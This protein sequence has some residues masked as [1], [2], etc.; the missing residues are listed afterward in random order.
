MLLVLLSLLSITMMSDVSTS[1]AA[2]AGAAAAAERVRRP[3]RSADAE[4]PPPELSAKRHPSQAWRTFG[5][6]EAPAGGKNSSRKKQKRG[7]FDAA[8]R[9]AAEQLRDK[10]VDDFLHQPVRQR[11]ERQAGSISS[12]QEQAETASRPTRS[13]APQPGELKPSNISGGS[14]P[15][16]C[17]AEYPVSPRVVAPRLNAMCI[18]VEPEALRKRE[19]Q[20]WPFAEVS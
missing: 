12:G 9:E 18:I 3:E 7:P 8:T 11:K 16:Q 4:Q 5:L 17:L 20:E 19:K 1:T 10:A 15:G 2:A 13:V 6:V 14:V